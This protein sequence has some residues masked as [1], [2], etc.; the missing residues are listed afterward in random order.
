[1]IFGRK[2]KAR[3][4]EDETEAE[5]SGATAVDPD[6]T[7]E[8]ADEPTG[9][10]SDVDVEP[11]DD[12]ADASDAATDDTADGGL[13][14]TALDETEWRTSGPF[15]VSELAD[16]DEPAD[17]KPRIDLGSLIISPVPG[18]ELRL[19]VNESQDIVSAM[20]VLPVTAPATNGAQPE[21]VGS[22]ALE[23]SAYAAPRSGGLWAELRDEISEAAA[24]VG[25]SAEL[26]AGP[27]GVELRRLLP[28]TTPDGEQGYQPSRMWVAEG[29]RWLL[30]GIV[31]GQ[32][33]IESDD[34]DP[35]VA[36]VLE[37]FRD[38]VVRRGD[39]AMAPGDL[40][41]MSMPA[42]LQPA[43]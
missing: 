33:A 27:F 11:A 5:T 21:V 41:P 25:G 4:A 42:D 20:L 30:R 8:A 40:L 38:V 29:P 26:A 15:E 2:K 36:A 37:A 23:L 3:S 24:E 32:A 13:D 28:V 12:A 1:M 19:Q 31:Y 35:A 14:T 43:E 10:T 16:D 17:D 34:D 7:A 9:P 39:E 22:S 18:S 6:G